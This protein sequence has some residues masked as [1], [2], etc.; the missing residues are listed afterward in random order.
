MERFVA[1]VEDEKITRTEKRRRRC[2]GFER[3]LHGFASLLVWFTFE[4]NKEDVSNWLCEIA[5]YL[6]DEL[7]DSYT[8]FVNEGEEVWR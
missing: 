8:N 4:R 2:V 5:D 6:F 1:C 3:V 7:E